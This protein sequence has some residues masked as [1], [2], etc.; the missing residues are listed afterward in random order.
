MIHDTVQ[1]LSFFGLIQVAGPEAR[2]F[3]QG[4]LSNDL[5]L[6]TLERTLLTSCNSPQGRVQAV[7]YLVERRDGI[8]LVLP[9]S[10]VPAILTRLRKYVLRTKVTISDMGAQLSVFGAHA[11]AAKKAGLPILTATGPAEIGA[12]IQQGETSIVRWRDPQERYLVIGVDSSFSRTDSGD[13][14]WQLSDIRA[15]L[16]QILPETWEHFVAQMLNLDLLDGISFTKGCYTGQEVIARTHYRGSIKRRLFRLQANC[17]PP[18]PGARVLAQGAHAGDVV[19]SAPSEQG[20][21]FLAVLTLTHVDDSLEL[22]DHPGMPLTHLTLPY[23]VPLGEFVK[24]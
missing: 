23:E 10:L 14:P 13:T 11:V 2:H 24:K 15:G 6:L 1:K 12:H 3:L 4:Q 16:P 22:A 20:C 18:S 9:A 7:V 5:Q 8:L 19:M 17:S 21:E